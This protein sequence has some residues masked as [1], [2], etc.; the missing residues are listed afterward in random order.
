MK[1]ISTLLLDDEMVICDIIKREISKR[2][3]LQAEFIEC[4]S[5][6]GSEAVKKL[7]SCKKAPQLLFIDLRLNNGLSGFDVIDEALKL[8]EK[9]DMYIAIL[10]GCWEGS[11]DWDRSMQYL[12][13]GKVDSLLGKWGIGVVLDEIKGILDLMEGER[14]G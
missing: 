5:G 4:P 8:F 14:S 9:E 13:E 1:R 6:T 10:T 11:E 7:K 12:N 2:K 3:N